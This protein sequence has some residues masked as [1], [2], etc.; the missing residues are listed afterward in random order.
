M[1]VEPVCCVLFF[2]SLFFIMYV[3]TRIFDMEQYMYRRRDAESV[4]VSHRNIYIDLGANDGSTVMSFLNGGTMTKIEERNAAVEGFQRNNGSLRTGLDMHDQWE[5]YV[6]EANPLYFEQLETQRESLLTTGRVKSY[7][8]FRATAIATFDGFV[9][10]ILDNNED[11]AAG[12]TTLGDSMSAVGRTI[13]V[14]AVDVVTL[15]RQFRES[16]TVVMKMDIEGGEYDLLRRMISRGLMAIV[17]RLAVEWH[18]DNQH[19]L[20]EPDDPTKASWRTRKTIHDKYK[21][22]HQHIIWMLQDSDYIH[23]LSKWG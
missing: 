4:L 10:F 19:V 21:A 13:N 12:S 14:T 3:F 5:I 20:G 22:A 6:F 2:S 9:P 1:R 17:D 18:H 7:K 23:K 15:F 8:L 16:D 11:G